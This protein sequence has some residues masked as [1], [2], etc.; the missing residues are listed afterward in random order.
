MPSEAEVGHLP[1]ID[2]PKRLGDRVYEILRREILNGQFSANDTL[3]EEQ[4]AK[5]FGVSRTPVREAIQRLKVEGL[6]TGTDGGGARVH[7]IDRDG[8]AQALEIRGV[9]E[10]YACKRAAKNISREQLSHLRELRNQELQGI[11]NN[12]LELMR[13]LNLAIHQ[14]ILAASGNKVLMHL[15][16]HLQARVPS[17]QLF[18]LGNIDNLR[19]FSESHAR[20]I[21]LLADRDAD[22]AAEEMS[23]HVQMAKDVMLGSYDPDGPQITEG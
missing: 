18:A 10:S 3:V 16:D 11:Q 13:Q 23:R 4:L 14:H 17:Y 12:D 5:Q 20:I 1:Q 22:G 7:A 6:V 19:K 8:I 21:D 15:V 2:R 9:L